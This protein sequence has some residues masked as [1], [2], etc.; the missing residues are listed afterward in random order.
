MSF[1]PGMFPGGALMGGVAAG[2]PPASFV[3]NGTNE[4]LTRTLST[5]GASTT[6]FTYSL[7]VKV[8][9]YESGACELFQVINA[10]TNSQWILS[11]IGASGDLFGMLQDAGSDD[12]SET[13][14]GLTPDV[15]TGT[16]EHWVIRY[17]STQG[18]ADNRIRFYRNGTLLSDTGTQ[19]GASEAHR[20][21]AN[22]Y[23]HQIGAYLDVSQFGNMKLAFIDVLEGVSADA[24][25]FAFDDGGTWTRMPYAGSYGTYG[26]N[27]DGTDSFNDASGNGQHFTGMNMDASNLDLADLPPWT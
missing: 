14:T 9:A 18:T 27:L 15:A 21:F 25:A 22:G 1:L 11:N 13:A 24:S 23:Q 3:F 17:D 16:W 7:W 5:S 19:P 8:I 12:W 10:P 6:I 26:F 2:P 20:L 4:A